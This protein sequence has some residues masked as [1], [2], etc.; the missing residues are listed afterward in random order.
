[1]RRRRVPQEP[2]R[3]YRLC[4]A[5]GS[6]LFSAAHGGSRRNQLTDTEEPAEK[7]SRRRPGEGRRLLLE[8]ARELFSERG[9]SRTSTREI[10]ERAGIAEA[11]LFRN[12]GSKATLYSEVALGSFRDFTSDW[13]R[14][15]AEIEPRTDEALAR[16]FVEQ[17]YDYLRTNRGL[18]LSYIA[19]S[20]FEPEVVP[21][22]RASPSLDALNTLAR[23]SQRDLPEAKKADPVRVLVANRALAGMIISMALFEDWLL[24]D[25]GEPPSREDVIDELTDF[26]LHRIRTDVKP[27]A[28]R[29][30]LTARRQ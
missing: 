30:R 19:M 20:V 21:F 13:K 15:S 17:F 24:P 27:N 8:S 1:M 12:F 11:L 29:A 4:H 7:R 23:W 18:I 10:A 25:V 22:D 16:A 26:V 28:G 3:W 2:T 14:V 5:G 6:L 9:Y